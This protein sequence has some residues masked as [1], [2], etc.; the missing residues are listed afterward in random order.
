MPADRQEL[1]RGVKAGVD[2]LLSLDEG[3]L[4]IAEGTG[5]TPILVPA[6]HGDL[7]SLVRAANDAE[8]R[9]IS[10]IVD[11]ILDPIHFGGANTSMEAFTMGLPV[12]TLP[13]RQ[14]RNRQSDVP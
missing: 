5:A 13:G 3:T 8:R 14:L 4:D 7:D 2:F 10:F 11:P 9:G 12:V 1:A 6:P